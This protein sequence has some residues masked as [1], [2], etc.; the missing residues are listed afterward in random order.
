MPESTSQARSQPVKV[1]VLWNQSEEGQSA[2]AEAIEA[3]ESGAGDE[4][5]PA[6][7]P[8]PRELRAGAAGSSAAAQGEDAGPSA[9]GAGGAQPG[10]MPAGDGDERAAGVARGEA[11][12]DDDADEALDDDEL[13]D[14]D[15]DEA[16]D[17][18]EVDEPDAGLED[19]EDGD[20][21]GLD[22]SAPEETDAQA[23]AEAVAYALTNQD[24]TAASADI[25]D[26][27]DRIIDSIVLERPAII[28]NL[29]DHVYGDATQHASVASLLDLLG[30]VYTGSD[31]LALAT[32]QD[33]VRTHLILDSAGVPVPG[34]VIV[35][36]VNAIPATSSLRAPLIV[37]QAFD[38][39]YDEE[40]AASPIE[41]RQ[42]L[43]E[44]L[45]E[46]ARDYDLPL[47]VEEYLGG[48]RLHAV[49]VGNRVLDVLPLCETR[50]DEDGEPELVLA[51]LDTDSADHVRSLA[52][53]AFRATGCRDVAQVDFHLRGRELVVTNVRPMLDFG[54]YAP[55]AVA[56][57]A[58]EGGYGGV[59][60]AIAREALGRS[61]PADEADGAVGA[62]AGASRAAAEGDAG[63]GQA[64]E[65]DAETNA[66][67]RPNGS[68][69][70]ADALS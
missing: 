51:Q 60:R 25:E 48:R 50:D 54:P 22:A 12:D 39:C 57:S 38:D 53:R 43:E 44:Y 17:D 40:G 26:D 65:R 55:L 8:L 24:F 30:I 5:A 52:Q 1:L 4:R 34:F 70:P 66:E 13:D 62:A 36:D 58:R 64:G 28:F 23:Q 56:A 69:P 49:V 29:V 41:S 27:I 68:A 33:R 20:G 7:S 61:R 32:C 15:A 47:L 14:D 21:A 35:R 2:E 11:L 46:L 18:D 31:P 19:D 42:R 9:K 10:D 59:V 67:D 37:T 45:Y 63:E 3:N 16:L 6:D